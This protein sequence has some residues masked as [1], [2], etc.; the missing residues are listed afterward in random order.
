[1][2]VDDGLGWQRSNAWYGGGRI[3]FAMVVL[4]SGRALIARHRRD[5]VERKSLSGVLLPVASACARGPKVA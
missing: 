3:A 5:D 1:M 4:E 2:V